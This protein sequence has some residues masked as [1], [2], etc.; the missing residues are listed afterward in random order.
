MDNIRILVANEPRS[1]REVIAAAVHELRPHAE[2]ITVEPA[3]LDRE[4]VHLEPHLVLC[5]RLTEVVETRTLAWVL[6]Y[7]DGEARAVISIAGQRRT[8]ANFAF[9]SLL[10]IVDQTEQLA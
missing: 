9:C 7:P 2:V 10:S 6:L 3:D 4:V 5:S 8:V 1:Y